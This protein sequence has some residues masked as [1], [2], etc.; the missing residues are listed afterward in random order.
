MVWID[1]I[2][3]CSGYK[4]PTESTDEEISTITSSSSK[5]K[6]R[7]SESSL[8]P[9]GGSLRTRLNR[10]VCHWPVPPPK[11]KDGSTPPCQL[12]K[13]AS[14]IVKKSG[15]TV[16]NECNIVLCLDCFE[17]FHFVFNIAEKK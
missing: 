8:H 4:T 15:I 13:W 5:Q 17:T 2:G 16:C 3:S 14:G 6:T 12:H 1:P 11:Y 9:L 10:N 7:L